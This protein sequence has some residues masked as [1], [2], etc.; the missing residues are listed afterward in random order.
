MRDEYWQAFFWV[1]V[2]ASWAFGFAYGRWAGGGGF[3]LELGKAVS[4]P[5]PLGF[6]SWWQPLVYFTLTI[7]AMFVLA[8]LFFGVGAAIF[9][10]ARGVSDSAVILALEAMVRPFPN[11]P[12]H[13]AW[14]L[15]LGMLILAVNLPLCIWSAHMGTQRTVYMWRRLR[16]QPMKPETATK[17]IFNFL[18]VMAISIV[19]GIVAAVAFSYA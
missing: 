18:I 4:V 9:L 8:Q 11:I 1:F 14:M 15:V 16:G 13:D 7:L 2:V 10:F 19:T 17:P 3:F 6:S 12:T 5:S